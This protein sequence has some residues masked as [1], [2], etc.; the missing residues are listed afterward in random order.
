MFDIHILS[1]GTNQETS[2]VEHPANDHLLGWLPGRNEILFVSDRS[3]TKDI[4]A[5]AVSDGKPGGVPWR[6]FNNI[7]DVNK[8]GF[9][10]NGSLL[11]GV[12]TTAFESFIVP[13]DSES[14]KVAINERTPVSGQR[15]GCTWLP[16]G[17]SLIFAEYNQDPAERTRKNLV[18]VNT[19]T[20]KSRILAE[21]LSLTEQFCIS[22]DGRS[23]VARGLD[24]Q[25]L[26]EKDYNGAIYLIDIET[27]VMTEV[28]TGHD[29]TRAWSCEWDKDGKNIFYFSTSDLVKHNLET[30]DEKVI[31]S[32]HKIY[33]TTMIRSHDGDN[34]LFHVRA[35]MNNDRF[36]LLSVPVNGGDA[37]TLATYQAF[38]SARFGRMALSPD[39]EYIYLTSRAPGLKSIL[40]RIPSTGGTP[41]NL[42][43]STYYFITGISVHPDGKKIALSTFETAREIRVIDNL[44]KKVTEIFDEKEKKE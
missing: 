31:Y 16:D 1:L 24:Q 41:E 36:H 38:G 34:L 10:R 12:E 9:T 37:D 8:M 22:P 18:I 25:R 40:C 11:F 42:W 6:I 33:Y 35:D 43:Q 7:G 27:G 20:G 2:V 17:E 39:G 21:N 5:V 44:D 32:A 3:G 13:L 30:G 19:G 26:N 15:F 23:A 28:K 4:W 14:G 29:L